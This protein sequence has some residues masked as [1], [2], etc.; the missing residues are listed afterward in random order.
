MVLKKGVS[1]YNSSFV[2]H[3]Y[4]TMIGELSLWTKDV[5]I[6][7]KKYLY[8][9]LYIYIYKIEFKPLKTHH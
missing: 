6:P 9:W 7:G 8:L 3:G 4:L 2:K 5:K 1:F